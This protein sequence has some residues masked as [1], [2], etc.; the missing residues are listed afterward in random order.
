MSERGIRVT[1]VDLETGD[2][3]SKVIEPGN[4]V[5]ITAAPCHVASEQHHA[6]GTSVITL[7]DRAAHLLTTKWVEPTEGGGSDA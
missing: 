5:L 7:K 6:N 4:Y 1:A 2:T 3:A